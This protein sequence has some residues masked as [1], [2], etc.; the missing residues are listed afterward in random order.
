[1]NVNYKIIGFH[2]DLYFICDTLERH[3]NRQ[4]A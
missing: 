2:F 1:M 3:K 4:Q